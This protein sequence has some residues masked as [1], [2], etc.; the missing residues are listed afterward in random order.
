VE[1]F[2]VVA[3]ET[4]VVAV[5]APVCDAALDAALAGVALAALPACVPAAELE[6]VVALDSAREAYAVRLRLS[7]A[8]S[9]AARKLRVFNFEF[10]VIAPKNLVERLA[11]SFAGERPDSPRLNHHIVAS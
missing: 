3:P 1:T 7:A 6:A 9:E 2:A 10:T 8:R 4:A 11:G 5:V